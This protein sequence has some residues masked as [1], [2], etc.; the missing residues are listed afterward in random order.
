MKTIYQQSKSSLIV[1]ERDARKRKELSE[2]VKRSIQM[3]AIHEDGVNSYSEEFSRLGKFV[4]LTD[5]ASPFEVKSL[6]LAFYYSVCLEEYD[7]F[8]SG[9]KG[10]VV[11]LIAAGER[12]EFEENRSLHKIRQINRSMIL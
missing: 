11:N 7:C 2:R 6:K 8:L 1:V 10:R 3:H 5:S 4:L 9:D 12:A